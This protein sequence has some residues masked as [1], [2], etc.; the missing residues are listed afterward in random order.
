MLK[1]LRPRFNLNVLFAPRPPRTVAAAQPPKQVRSPPRKK[2]RLDDTFFDLLD[3]QDSIFESPPP[4]P[5]LTHRPH[6]YP[7]PLF[8]YNLFHESPNPNFN[9]NFDFDPNSLPLTLS[10]IKQNNQEPITDLTNHKFLR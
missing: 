5:N 9:T 3:S 6:T 8:Q 7:Q 1:H 2:A 10:P 4:I